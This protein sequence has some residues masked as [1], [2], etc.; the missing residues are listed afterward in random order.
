M[1]RLLASARFLFVDTAVRI[2]KVDVIKVN[3]MKRFFNNYT[4][5]KVLFNNIKF[6][7]TELKYVFHNQNGILTLLINSFTILSVQTLI[8]LY[9]H[10]LLNKIMSNIV[11][12]V[13][14]EISKL[15]SFEMQSLLTFLY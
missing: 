9:I 4:S 15:H 10:L 11:V 14:I 7:D 3:C 13:L 12:E 6:I 1:Y 8:I 2:P 5:T